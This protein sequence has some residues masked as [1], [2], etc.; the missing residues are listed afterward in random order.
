MKADL[1]RWIVTGKRTHLDTMVN[2]Y[3]AEGQVQHEPR[4]QQSG[5]LG[6]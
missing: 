6:T 1:R 4:L 3:R 2:F 5:G